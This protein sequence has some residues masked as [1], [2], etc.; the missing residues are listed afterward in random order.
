MAQ[1]RYKAKN[2]RGKIIHGSTEAENDAELYR[3]LEKKELYCISMSAKRRDA[4]GDG[5]RGRKV[6][7]KTVSIFCRE[8]SVLLTSGMNLLTALQL[9]YEREE[10]A[11]VKGSYMR[12]IEDIEKGDTF[13]EAIRRQGNTWPSLLRAMILAGETSGSIDMVMDKMALY[14]EKEASLKSKVQNAMIYPM[15]LIGVTFAVIILLFTFVLPRFFDMF[16]GQSVPG[17]TAAFMAISRFMTNYWYFLLLA[18]LAIGCLIKVLA[19]NERTGVKLDQ[20]KRKLPVFGKL[21]EK[22]IMGH[23]ANAM[24]ILYASGVTIVKAL[25]ISGGTI[26]NRYIAEK[27]ERVREKVEKGVALSQALQSEGMFDKMFWSM[28]HIG[29]ESGNLETMFFKLSEYLEQESEAAVLKMMAVLEPLVL[30]I[31]AIVIGAVVAS[32]L[33]PIFNMYQIS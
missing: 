10:K 8:L 28:V 7:L 23:F 29:E 13:Y 2:L 14:Y 19:E 6:K 3:Y 27:L 1:Y 20:I 15:I 31:I 11:F 24:S 12:M 21:F 25:E 32:V 17:I 30:I 18:L 5:G 26:S 22:V 4:Y 33:L 9:L 16:E